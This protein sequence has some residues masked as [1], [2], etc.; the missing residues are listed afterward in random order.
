MKRVVI[1]VLLILFGGM[2]VS[3]LD[4]PTS[5]VGSED[6]EKIQEAIEDFSPLDESG[7]I[8]FEKYK[9]LTSDAERRI[10]EINR[11]IG[12][13][14]NALFGVELSLSW[15]FIFSLVMWILLI[16]LIIVPMSSIFD[17]NVW[18]SL[19]GAGMAASL[20]MQGFGKDFVIYMNSLMTQWWAGLIVLTGS[21]I[22][23]VVYSA[24]MKTA[25]EKLRIA[26][27]KEAKRKTEEDRAVISAVAKVGEESLKG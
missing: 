12:P 6:V 14:A 19:A 24:F 11:Y 5:G 13:F 27:E 22:V 23:G 1:F 20:A 7:D 16:E 21:I 4:D 2:F 26:K 8:D 10:E 25:G 9:P 18:W 17:W 3:G 15:I